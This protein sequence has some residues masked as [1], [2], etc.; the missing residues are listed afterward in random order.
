MDEP[1]KIFVFKSTYLTFKAERAIKSA[2][3]ECKVVTKP[4]D[5]SSDCGLALRVRASDEE[6]AQ[7]AITAKDIKSLG[8]W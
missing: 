5:I 8:V 4:R 2:G 3:I 1:V 7:A 6:R